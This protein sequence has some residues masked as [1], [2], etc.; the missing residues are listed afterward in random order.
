VATLP[1]AAA[2]ADHIAAEAAKLQSA[3]AA[4]AAAAAAGAAANTV[5]EASVAPTNAAAAAVP[6][7]MTFDALGGAADPVLADDGMIKSLKPAP[8]PAALFLG[9]PAFG[10]GPLAG[11]L[12]ITSPQPTL[13]LHLPAHIGWG[14]QTGMARGAVWSRYLSS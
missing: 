12:L 2:I 6:R 14:G 1:T 8:K 11:G 9:A 5:A 10:D 3:A 4:A 13:S 7:E